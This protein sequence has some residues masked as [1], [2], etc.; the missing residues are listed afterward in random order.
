MKKIGVLISLVLFSVSMSFAAVSAS[1]SRT[2]VENGETI[3]LTLHLENF[4]TQPNLSVLDK[5]FTVYNTSTSSK[6]S[7][8]NGKTTAQY[9]MI[10]T[11]M[12]NKTGKLTIPAI[13]V[14]SEYTKP[15]AIN[16]DK[17]LSNDEE[18]KYQDIFAISTIASDSSYINVP[19]LY[20]IK[21][22]YSTPILGLQ[23]KPFKI[24]KSEIRPTN[25]RLTYQKRINGNLY[26]VNEESF[27]IVPHK[28]GKVEIPPMVLQA[29]VSN[30]F[31]QLGVK[32]RF[33][34]TK[35]H[36]LN[37]KPIP[38]NISIKD[39]FPSSDV[40]IVDG[41]SDDKNVTAGGLITRT[42]KITAKDV[43]SND[44]PKLDFKSTDDFNIY[45][46]KPKLE[47]VEKSGKLT[48]TATYKIGYMPTKEGKSEVS[49]L[50]LKWYDVD[51]HKSKVASIAAKEFDVKKG[52][53]ANTNFLG[54]ITPDAT[55][56]V[57]KTVVDPF[58]KNV[59]IA[60]AVL[61]VITLLLL[62]KC[63]FSKSKKLSFVEFEENN[64]NESLGIKD[65]KK[66]CNKKDNAGL[67]KALVSWASQRFDREIFSTLEISNLVPEL[68][69]ILKNLNAAMYSN[70]KFDGYAELLKIVINADK[71]KNKKKYNK[72]IKG[73]YE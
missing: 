1:I 29:T 48:G 50:K 10:V 6:V 25:H 30:G 24:D 40:S 42:V 4:N 14:G 70:K 72:Q 57:E 2:N 65:I 55:K 7:T 43:L 20:T 49:E 47:D 67:Q 54:S 51:A 18:D 36:T 28:T 59:S 16:V 62:L 12:P 56:V 21:I 8:I 17:A 44:I 61:W 32:T 26:D 52:S 5:D 68:D 73:L 33:V 64:T 34:S 9:D 41:W 45:A 46:E 39:W 66:A 13:K 60:L 71:L 11:I 37:V 53:V 58:W 31:G 15:I 38:K 63:R 27:L 22:Y 3:D 19:V 69:S 35:G 23:P